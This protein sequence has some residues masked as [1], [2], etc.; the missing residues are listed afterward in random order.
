MTVES[1]TKYRY[2][3]WSKSFKQCIHGYATVSSCINNNV[4]WQRCLSPWV[5]MYTEVRI[6]KNFS[7]SFQFQHDSSG[8]TSKFWAFLQEIHSD[9]LPL[10]K[11]PSITI[12]YKHSLQASASTVWTSILIYSSQLVH[13]RMKSAL[14]YFQPKNNAIIFGSHLAMCRT[15]QLRNYN[16]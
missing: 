3:H 12:Y 2:V 10:R 13:V 7:S 11:G 1:I 15:I 4:Y 8:V 5:A 9:P 14:Q 6:C 16:Y